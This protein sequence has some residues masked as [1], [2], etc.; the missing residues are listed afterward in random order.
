M[1][2]E[3]WV[4]SRRIVIN[5]HPTSLRLE[6]EFWYWLREIGAECGISA[7]KLIAAIN[8][9]RNPDRSLSSALRIAV[10]GYYHN[11]GCVNTSPVSRVSTGMWPSG[12]SADDRG[13]GELPPAALRYHAVGRRNAGML[14]SSW[15]GSIACRAVARSK[16]A[17]GAAAGRLQGGSRGALRSLGAPPIALPDITTGR[18]QSNTLSS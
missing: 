15:I 11:A 8:T 6:P 7:T 13:I 2:K 14:R 10:A 16:R 3:K 9:A 12:G 1:P 4:K 17:C 18:R 5:D